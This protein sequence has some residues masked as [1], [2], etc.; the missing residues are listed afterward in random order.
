MTEHI[1]NKKVTTD[2]RYRFEYLSKF[3][4]FTLNDIT[5]LNTLA[6]V[7]FPRIPV[8]A[9]T[10]YRKLFSFDATKQYFLVRHQGFDNI[11]ANQ[12]IDSALETT[13]MT[14]RKDMLSMYLKRVLTQH[15]WNDTFLQYLSQVGRM[16][17]PQAG[18]SSSINVDYIHINLLLGYLEHLIIDILWNAENLDDQAKYTMVTAINKFFWIQ[19]DFFTMHYLSSTKDDLSSTE[20]IT[21]DSHSCC[22]LN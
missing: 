22:I 21:K 7:L 13:Q 11:S 3:L 8:I 2:L 5:A 14:F 10:V 20:K 18:S 17:T 6:P 1:D 16:H 15:E 12:E 4:N 19:N 9:D